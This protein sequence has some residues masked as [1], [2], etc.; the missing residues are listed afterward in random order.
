M[1]K[2]RL[3]YYSPDHERCISFDDK[4]DCF[5]ESLLQ[6]EGKIAFVLEAESR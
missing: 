1:F 6:R 5:K 2:T 4:R 3:R